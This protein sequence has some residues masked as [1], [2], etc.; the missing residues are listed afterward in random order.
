MP[1]S[2]MRCLIILYLSLYVSEINEGEIVRVHITYC[3]DEKP[4]KFISS[5][6]HRRILSGESNQYGNWQRCPKRVRQ[7]RR[8]GA[9]SSAVL[10]YAD[11]KSPAQFN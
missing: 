4:I 8:F 3:R 11:K 5:R 10:N 1:G 2:R 9:P 7:H 6:N